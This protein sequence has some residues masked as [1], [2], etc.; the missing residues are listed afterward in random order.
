MGDGDRAWP[1]VAAA[2]APLRVRHDR[3]ETGSRW[4]DPNVRAAQ[5]DLER[6]L[7]VRVRIR[8]RKGKGEITLEY[9][10][11][12]DFDR[13]LGMLTGKGSR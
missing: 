7:G 5:L 1:P 11:L 12:E 3:A 10:T 6:M 8:D 9:S 2:L 4:Q 13:V